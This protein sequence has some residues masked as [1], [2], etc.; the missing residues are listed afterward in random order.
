[1][2]VVLNEGVKGSLDV[3]SNIREGRNTRMQR[4]REG[5]REECKQACSRQSG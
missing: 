5:D 2:A 1:M 4:M 3:S